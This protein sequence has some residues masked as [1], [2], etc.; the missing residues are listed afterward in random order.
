[1]DSLLGG[2]KPFSHQ[3]LHRITREAQHAR[4]LRFLLSAEALKDIICDR[5]RI[6]RATN[7]HSDPMEIQG[8]KRSSNVF[9]T[10]VSRVTT[11]ELEPNRPV[12]Q[13]EVIVDHDQL[14]GRNLVKR[15][16]RLDGGTR[17]VHEA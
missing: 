14:G 3:G 13:I 8:A 4:K 11:A 9:E 5:P 1:M 16:H 15:E 2:G 17:A 7:T 6:I 12:G 10:V